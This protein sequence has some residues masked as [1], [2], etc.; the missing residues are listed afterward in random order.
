MSIFNSN[1]KTLRKRTNLSPGKF[2]GLLTK[3][4]DYYNRLEEGEIQ[5]AIE[6]IIYLAFLHQVE[7]DDLLTK[8]LSHLKSKSLKE[9]MIKEIIREIC[10][11]F[12]LTISQVNIKS[13]GFIKIS[14]CRQII[15]Y[16][17]YEN[18]LGTLQQISEYL[19]RN[20]GSVIHGIKA[21]KD[22]LLTDPIFRNNFN[23]IEAR[24]KE[25]IEQ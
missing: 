20:H 9:K 23:N 11:Y 22:L 6:E 25:I 4:E 14:E 21:V 2:A 12:G 19:G 13:R 8:D 17:L 3:D 1:I 16:F 15:Y 24:V 10:D 18:H 7:I 5:P